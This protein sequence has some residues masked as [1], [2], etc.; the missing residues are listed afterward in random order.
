M[1]SKSFREKLQATQTH[2]L[3]SGEVAGDDLEGKDE[4]LAQ[5]GTD[6]KWLCGRV[7]GGAASCCWERRSRWVLSS[8]KATDVVRL[9][10]GSTA[11]E[12]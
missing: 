9:G 3:N 6:R 10:A 4:S 12:P 2:E 5:D 7:G 8:G 1:Y 11:I